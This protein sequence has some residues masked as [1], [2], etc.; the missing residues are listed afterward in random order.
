[1]RTPNYMRLVAKSRVA[2]LSAVETYNRASAM[3]REETF[4][5]LMIN[6]WELLLKARIMRENGGKAS[7]L[8]EL[9][10]R[11]KR[12]GNASKLKEVKRTRSGAPMTIGI[13]RCWKLV[14]GYSADRID[15]ACISN[16]E[17]LVEIRDIATH[18]V[19]TDALL[20]K[21]L[22][23]LSLA[24]VRNY[25]IAAQAWFKVSFSDLNIAS[26]PISFDL[27]HKQVEAVAK[28]SSDAVAKFLAHMQKVEGSLVN[29]ASHFAF[30]IRVDFDLIKKHAE[31]AVKAAVVAD[32]E[33]DLRVSLKSDKVPPGFD[34]TYE[35]LIGR[36]KAKYADFKQN[37]AFHARMKA[38]KDNEKLCYERYLDPVNKKGGK[39]PFFSPNVMK[40]FDQHYMV[41][42]AT[43]F[44]P[45][46]MPV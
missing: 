2:C 19:A 10:Q 7:A 29:E 16:I 22:T 15:M 28:K 32:A 38:I 17:A 46:P 45:E 44:E 34:W 36:I 6:A 39:K 12:D 41:K 20:Q 23:E 5:I 8:Y 35:D 27:D 26:I 37:K 25:V 43:L 21:K 1:L 11:K 42:G 13:D 4:A 33:A 14:S 9:K 3:Y 31:G 40:E 18:F 30:T 24:A